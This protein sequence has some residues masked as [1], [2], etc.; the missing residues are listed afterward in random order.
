MPMH[1]GL[2]LWDFYTR[3]AIAATAD[4]PHVL[5]SHLALMEKPVEAVEK[6]LNALAMHHVAGLRMPTARE[7]T[8][9]ISLD[10]YRE[11]ATRE[12]L[13]TFKEAPQVEL[14]RKLITTPRQSAK[15]R[16][17]VPTYGCLAAYERAVAEPL[18]ALIE[19]E[20]TKKELAAAKAT[21]V[22][23]VT[24]R[25]ERIKALERAVERGA[26]EGKAATAAL[27]SEVLKRDERIKALERDVA[28]A[29]AATSKQHEH[30]VAVE[31]KL[32]ACEAWRLTAEKE[33]QARGEESISLRSHIRDLEGQLL[34]TKESLNARE[35][36]ILSLKA[37][38]DEVESRV[39]LREKELAVVARQIAECQDLCESHVTEVAGVKSA[40]AQQQWSLSLAVREMLAL[41]KTP[42][43]WTL[44]QLATTD[45]FIRGL[46]SRY[47]LTA[48]ASL[49]KGSGLFDEEWYCGQH[50]D[51]AESGLAPVLHYLCFGAARMSDPGPAFQSAAYLTANPDVYVAGA[52]PLL[53]YIVHGKAEGRSIE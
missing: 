45:R 26:A 30:V 39:R 12:D 32:Q 49:L 31:K 40:M 36:T 42:G 29:V 7:I 18:P 37:D 46:P 1:A 9:F 19:A 5:V 10:L 34:H 11:R 44:T 41:R 50:G 47:P 35:T 51:V 25:D 53:H 43:V 48:A 22:T 13:I 27:Q 8:A 21:A 20:K 3:N 28:N 24:N 14:Y 52:N 6:L 4:M 2:E 33:V 17:F 16:P 23:E 15:L 38:R